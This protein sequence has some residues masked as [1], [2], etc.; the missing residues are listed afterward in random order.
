VRQAKP[1]AKFKAV[2]PEVFLSNPQLLKQVKTWI[3]IAGIDYARKTLSETG[4]ADSSI[5]KIVEAALGK[6]L[7]RQSTQTSQSVA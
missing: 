2:D 5:E 7:M 6:A 4:V 1:R 3:D